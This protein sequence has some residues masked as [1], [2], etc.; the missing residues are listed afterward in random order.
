[1]I[2]YFSFVSVF[3]F[4]LW[5]GVQVKSI[6]NEPLEKMQVQKVIEELGGE[7]SPNYPDKLL[8]GASAEIGE[9]IIKFG[10]SKG[11]E[12]GMTVR[13][14]K[15]FV[16]T[17]CHN[18]E[19]ESAYLN[20]ED[21]EERL[22]Y[23]SEKG[24][25]FLQGSP[26]FGIVNRTSFYNGDYE[27]KYGDLVIKARNNIR[28]AIQLCAVECSQG[29][30]LKDWEVESILMYLWK[31]DLKLE[32]LVLEEAELDI[33]ESA[34][35]EGQK[36][37]KAKEIIKSKYL[38]K[39]SAHFVNPPKNYKVGID[40]I[41]GNPDNGGEIY[42][43]ACLYCHE[44]NDYSFYELDS[45]KLT[46]RQLRNH[47][48]IYDQRSFYHVVRYGTKPMGGKKAYMPHYT[49]EKMSDQQME[50]LRSYILREAE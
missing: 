1:M 11:L 22:A 12:G 43:K 27:K 36:K 18:V 21:P 49:K 48:D 39:A 30:A 47:M 2:K 50:D 40:S 19:Q 9:N 42:N 24:L 33:I 10:N 17:S 3:L 41:Q 16:C 23:T 25:P 29:R 7:R 14:S 20:I 34:I 4:V 5:L 13:Q 6:N 46:F 31:I 15:H 45:E 26:L 32:N 8:V 28:E 35:Y 38:S 37:D 44:R